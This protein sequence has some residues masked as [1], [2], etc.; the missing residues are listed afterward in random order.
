MALADQYEAVYELLGGTPNTLQTSGVNN[1]VFPWLE[2]LVKGE[3]VD[4]LEVQMPLA[5]LMVQKGKEYRQAA[6][7][8]F[9]NYNVTLVL[10]NITPGLGSGEDEGPAVINQFAGWIG[11]IN[12]LIR[13][14]KQL[15]TPSYPNGAA[16]RFG[17]DSDYE[18]EHQRMENDIVIGCVWTILSTEEVTA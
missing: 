16:I 1:T 10:I 9:I 11:D 5:Y 4:N 7:K 14:N 12:N 18:E 8:K 15:K 2:T 13:T 3:L 17:E 6:Q